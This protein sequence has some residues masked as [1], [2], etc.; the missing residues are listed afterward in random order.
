LRV[1]TQSAKPLI[2]PVSGWS[3]LLIEGGR[4]QIYSKGR[5]KRNALPGIK[6]MRLLQQ[7]Y[8]GLSPFIGH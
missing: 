3:L 8:G 5:I 2:C 4:W 6:E 1:D 7:W